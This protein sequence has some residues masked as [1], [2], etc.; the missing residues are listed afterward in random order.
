MEWVGKEP[1]NAALNLWLNSRMLLNSV[2][3][4]PTHHTKQWL[5]PCPLILPATHVAIYSWLSAYLGGMEPFTK[6]LNTHAILKK[7]QES[8]LGNFQHEQL[9]YV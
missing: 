2:I 4:I 6:H 9:F 7:L 3:S 1:E 8:I 5:S